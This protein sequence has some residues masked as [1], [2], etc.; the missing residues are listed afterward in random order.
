M[1][2]FLKVVTI[3]LMATAFAVAI[4]PNAAHAERLS[5]SASLR[6]METGEV[7]VR[8]TPALTQ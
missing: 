3:T 4:S 2:Y 8:D 1:I 7:L 6:I 5:H